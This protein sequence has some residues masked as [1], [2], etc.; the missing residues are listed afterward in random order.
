MMKFTLN[1]LAGILA[2]SVLATVVAA[3]GTPGKADSGIGFIQL[4]HIS[5]IDAKN[6]AVMLSVAKDEKNDQ[7]S[8]PPRPGGFARGGKFGRFGLPTPDDIVKRM[9]RTY[10]T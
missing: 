5:R 10:E 2:V 1:T 8:T 3:K 4:G 7:P 9:Q 6:H